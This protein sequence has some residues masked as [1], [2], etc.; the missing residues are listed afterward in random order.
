MTSRIP[1]SLRFIIVAVGGIC[2]FCCDAG[3]PAFAQTRIRIGY[4]SGMN[5]QIPV[6]MQNAGID[7]KH[8]FVAEFTAFQ[9]GPPMLEALASGSL[10]GIVTSLMPVVSYA[11]K[12]PGDL[13]IVAA[14]GHS[15]YALLVSQ[16]STIEGWS[17]LVGRQIAVSF[18]S[19][20]HMDT[21]RTL[22][23]NGLDGKIT[24]QNI[25]PAELALAL[26]KGLTDAVVIRQPQS[27]RLR[28]QLGAKSLHVWPFYFVACV[29]DKFIADNADVVS[30][31]VAALRDASNY[32]S[33]NREEAGRWFGEAMRIDPR[34]VSA[35][36]ADDE[37]ST[38]SGSDRSQ[39][40]LTPEFKKVVSDWAEASY[41]LGM[42]KSRPDISRM[43]R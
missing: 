33:Q 11:T 2:A 18:N 22:K 23:A 30:R 28:E 16:A 41:A 42:V 1:R 24:L 12:M 13:R 17:D 40:E 9:Y 29:R 26:E 31:Y 43:F 21:L 35:A 19:D 25:A 38:S 15:S 27:L 5:G 39:V 32:I 36:V 34:I 3:T 8:G 20:S 6:V 37:K 4:P 14:L 7:R 10:D